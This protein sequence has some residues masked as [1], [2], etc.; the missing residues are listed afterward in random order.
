LL[1]EE[2]LNNDTALEEQQQ[3][4]RRVLCSLLGEERLNNDTALEEQQ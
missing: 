2:R 3:N 1:G 4:V